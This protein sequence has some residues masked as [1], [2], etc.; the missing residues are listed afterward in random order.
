VASLPR[1][2]YAKSG[3]VHI[4]YEVIGEGERDLVFVQGMMSHLDLMWENPGMSRLFRGLAAFNR[5]ILFDK[6]GTGLSDR[7][8]GIADLEERM[9]DVRAVMDA[10]GSKR[11]VVMA[12]SEGAPMA[13]VFAASYPERVEALILFGAMARATEAPGYPW[14]PTDEGLAEV[15]ELLNDTLF[16]GEDIEAWA[17]SLADNRAAIEWLGRYR[18]AGIS[19]DGVEALFAMFSAIDVRDVLPTLRVPTLVMH[20]HGDR[21]VNRRAGEWIAQQI[22]GARFLDLPGQDHLPWVGDK[23][24]ILEEVREFLTGARVA[25]EPDRVLTTVMFTDIVGSTEIAASAGDAQWREILD[26]H[27]DVVRRQL[28]AFR[29]REIKTIGDAFLATFDGPARAIRC[30]AAIRDAITDID[31]ELRFGLHT[32]EVELR[33]DDIAG[34]AVVVAQRIS[35]LA[36]AGEVLVSSTVKDLVAGSGIEFEARGEHEL[37]GV[38]ESWRLFTAAV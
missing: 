10:A 37:K 32:G 1:V 3:P 22:P 8:V 6:R 38:P 18:R 13:A 14:A 19:P 24:V 16:S 17:P 9:D 15:G 11:A 27:D 35:A 4:A 34:L 23:D 28:D 7:A 12:V 30:A 33:G 36:A 2:E 20:R 31:L 5:L 26:E 29:G 21:V 25:A